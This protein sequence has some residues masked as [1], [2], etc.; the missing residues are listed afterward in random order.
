MR[1]AGGGYGKERTGDFQTMV[2]GLDFSLR[3]G[4]SHQ[5]VLN[6]KV[7]SDFCFKSYFSGHYVENWEAVVAIGR[8]R[9]PPDIF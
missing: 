1:R 7:I 4:G 5:K 6:R 2:E 9:P 3:A 8:R